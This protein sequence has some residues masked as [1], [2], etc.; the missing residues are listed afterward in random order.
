M[1]LF[2]RFNDVLSVKKN[3][4]TMPRDLL[5]QQE[6]GTAPFG[7]LHL[8]SLPLLSCESD[9]L[10]PSFSIEAFTFSETITV[11]FCN[12]VLKDMP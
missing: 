5:K 2:F 6:N 8:V 9:T 12:P 3:K 10:R 11:A 7:T 4:G 1:I